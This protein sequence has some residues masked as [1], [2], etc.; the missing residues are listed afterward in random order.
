MPSRGGTISVW[1]GAGEKE[2]QMDK[3]S[4]HRIWD[5]VRRRFVWLLVGSYVIAGVFP[6]PG[7]KLRAVAWGSINVPMLYRFC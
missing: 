4:A 3:Q 2:R 1:V 6:D 7:L 5:F